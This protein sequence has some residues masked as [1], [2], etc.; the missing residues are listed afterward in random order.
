[1]AKPYT[2]SI[3]LNCIAQSYACNCEY[4]NAKPFF[5]EALEIRKQLLPENDPHVIQCKNNVE[6]IN[7]ILSE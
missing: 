1:M 5:E 6:K 3:L 4:S 2:K 7:E